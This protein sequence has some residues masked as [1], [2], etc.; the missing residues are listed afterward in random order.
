[1]AVEEEWK[2]PKDPEDLERI[3]SGNVEQRRG[4]LL[5]GLLERQNWLKEK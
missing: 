4:T 5:G 2:N 1:M 3:Q